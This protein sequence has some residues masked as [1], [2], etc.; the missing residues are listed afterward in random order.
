MYGSGCRVHQTAA[1]CLGTGHS[2]LA[3]LACGKGL[4]GSRFG[5]PQNAGLDFAVK[6]HAGAWR[7]GRAACRMGKFGEVVWGCMPGWGAM[8]KRFGAACL[9][10]N[11]ARWFGA[12]CA[13]R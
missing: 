9:V 12:A 5:L 1:A 6:L 7:G 2:G 3:P 10:G 4:G 13:G 8:A 11:S